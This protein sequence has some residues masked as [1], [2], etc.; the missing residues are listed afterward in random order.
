MAHQL[1]DETLAAILEALLVVSDKDF[2]CTDRMSPF[3]MIEQPSSSNYL[4]VCKRWMRIGTPLLYHT[5]VMRSQAQATALAA[6]LKPKANAQFGQYIR[7]LRIEG[8][9]GVAA[10]N[11]LL[12]A[13]NITDLS[14]TLNLSAKDNVSPM[15]DILLTALMPQ[16]LVIAASSPST[17]KQI[18]RLT[19]CLTQCIKDW[20]TLV[21]GLDLC[22]FCLFLIHPARLV[23]PCPKSF[24]NV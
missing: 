10:K 6:V 12:A 24:W 18:T 4:V 22:I 23:S 7:K 20:S 19:E 21:C 13:R 9:F 5:V 17:N 3:S 11:V 8:G 16:R 2:A 14:V 15:C 1:A